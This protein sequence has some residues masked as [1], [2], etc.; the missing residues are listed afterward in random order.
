MLH[1]NI[2]ALGMMVSEEKFFLVS[3]VFHVLSRRGPLAAY[4]DHL[5]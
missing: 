5:F 2:E 1:T 4:L 3:F